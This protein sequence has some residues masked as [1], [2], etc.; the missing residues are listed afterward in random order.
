MS[1]AIS[2]FSENIK[3]FDGPSDQFRT[4][5]PCNPTPQTSGQLFSHFLPPSASRPWKKTQIPIP[6]SKPNYCPEMVIKTSG[7][8]LF[9]ISVFPWFIEFVGCQQLVPSWQ[10][11]TTN[12]APGLHWMERNSVASRFYHHRWAPHQVGSRY[13]PYITSVWKLSVNTFTVLPIRWIVC[14][15]PTFTYI[16]YRKH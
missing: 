13:F 8:D 10:L 16:Y 14:Y 9:F 1:V 3:W 15:I 6:M 4:H 11:Q 12:A 5:D 7:K 2:N